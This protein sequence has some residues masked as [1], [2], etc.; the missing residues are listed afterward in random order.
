MFIIKFFDMFSHNS[1]VYYLLLC[2]FYSYVKIIK[3]KNS[4]NCNSERYLMC[5]NFKG[6]TVLVDNLFTIIKNFQINSHTFTLV[7]PYFNYYRRV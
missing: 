6:C 5:Y 3:P 2:A 7:F 1:I 4:R